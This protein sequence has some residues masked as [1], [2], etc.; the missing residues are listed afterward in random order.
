MLLFSNVDCTEYMYVSYVVDI[1][2]LGNIY[3]C[4]CTNVKI[5]NFRFRSVKNPGMYWFLWNACFFCSLLIVVI[6]NN[7]S[8][9]SNI[10]FSNLQRNWNLFSRKANKNCFFCWM[11]LRFKIKVMSIF[12]TSKSQSSKIDK[13]LDNYIT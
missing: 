12:D 3:Q 8:I 9:K 13:E 10:P 5:V 11:I 1:Y 4:F 6:L 2:F 7:S